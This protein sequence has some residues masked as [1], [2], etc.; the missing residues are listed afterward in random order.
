M[1]MKKCKRGEMDNEGTKVVMRVK[2]IINYV[3]G[4]RNEMDDDI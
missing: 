3:K 1:I 4:M 2:M